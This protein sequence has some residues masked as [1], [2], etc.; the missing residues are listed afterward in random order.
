[1]YSFVHL[2]E[3]LSFE[4]F[5][6]LLC[7]VIITDVPRTLR[8]TLD[9][10]LVKHTTPPECMFC[11]YTT[12]PV[13]C[14]SGKANKGPVCLSARKERNTRRET[15]QDGL[16][17]VCGSVPIVCL[18]EPIKRFRSLVNVTLF[19]LVFQCKISQ[20]LLKSKH[21][22]CLFPSSICGLFLCI[23]GTSIFIFFLSLLMQISF[24]QTNEMH[25]AA[26]L[27]WRWGAAS[28]SSP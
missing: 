25:L 10:W 3:R 27:K 1:M 6:M 8:Y 12:L 26:S 7:M 24:W 18:K 4:Q 14:L 28:Y 13:L 21:Y 15:K 9:L 17:T 2:Q 16:S 20:Y 11:I 23:H 5:V 22:F 19:V